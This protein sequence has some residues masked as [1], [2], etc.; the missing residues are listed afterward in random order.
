MKDREQ[1]QTPSY[2]ISCP[3]AI[4]NFCPVSYTVSVR[5]AFF[6]WRGKEWGAR[7]GAPHTTLRQQLVTDNLLDLFLILEGMI[8]S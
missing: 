2:L 6:V 3:E 7:E 8:Y 4:C 5:G 1:K